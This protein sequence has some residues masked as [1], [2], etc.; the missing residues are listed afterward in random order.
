MEGKEEGC[1]CKLSLKRLALVGD[2]ENWWRNS[3]GKF[4]NKSVET[5]IDMDHGS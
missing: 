1:W 2:M 3:L 4:S 5:S